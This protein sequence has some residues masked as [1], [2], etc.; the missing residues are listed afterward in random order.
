MTLRKERFCCIRIALA[1]YT[2]GSVIYREGS[3]GNR[4][5]PFLEGC[6]RMKNLSPPACLTFAV[7]ARLDK[8]PRECAV[9]GRSAKEHASPG[10]R[11]LTD[12][13][14]QAERLGETEA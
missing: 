7:L 13:E 9:C 14:I 12:A 3:P 2:E 8:E 1:R 10:I 6:P 5:L 4:A 11:L